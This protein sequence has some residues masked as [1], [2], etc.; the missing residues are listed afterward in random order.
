MC[1]QKADI[2][3]QCVW[4][5]QVARREFEKLKMVAREKESLQ[6]ESVS[7]MS[8]SIG[9]LVKVERIDLIS[10][11][12]FLCILHPCFVDLVNSLKTCYLDFVLG[13]V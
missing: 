2:V 5:R 4:R 13:K 10:V 1:L 7:K 11:D 6:L 8:E 9:P 3:S 12:N